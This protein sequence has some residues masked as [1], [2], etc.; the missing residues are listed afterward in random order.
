MASE[1]VEVLKRM[2]VFRV[3][4]VD[5]LQ[6]VHQHY[7]VEKTRSATKET[8]LIQQAVNED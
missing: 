7:M 1:K 8:V 6:E 4:F 5:V 3:T 2:W